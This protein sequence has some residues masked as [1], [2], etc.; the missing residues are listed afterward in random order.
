MWSN[1]FQ[2]VSGHQR[3]VLNP[4]SEEHATRGP[5]RAFKNGFRTPPLH[6]LSDVATLLRRVVSPCGGTDDGRAK[7]RRERVGYRGGREDHGEAVRSEKRGGS[8]CTSSVLK[9]RAG[10]TV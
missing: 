9:T 5:R 7:A 10:R 4:H 2:N 3:T 6:A 1:T 8:V